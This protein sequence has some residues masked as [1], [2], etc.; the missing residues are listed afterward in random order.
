M[1]KNVYLFCFFYL[2]ITNCLCNAAQVA[3][4]YHTKSGTHK[5]IAEYIAIGI[6]KT[7]VHS[8]KIINVEDFEKAK[9]SANL[10]FT[11]FLLF[12]KQNNIYKSTKITFLHNQIFFYV[13]HL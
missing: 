10:I 9:I 2:I 6:E 13:I 11:F 7:N 12:K 3:I 5:K 1:F 4:V 8:V